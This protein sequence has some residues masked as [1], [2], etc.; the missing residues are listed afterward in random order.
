MS[1]SELSHWHIG[2]LTIRH[3][4]KTL[5]TNGNEAKRGRGSGLASSARQLKS[6]ITS[7]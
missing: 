4:W 1:A 5:L 2:E 7:A 6:S 3:P